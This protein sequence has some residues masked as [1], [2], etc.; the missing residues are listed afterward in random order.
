MEGEFEKPSSYMSIT[1]IDFKEN[2]DLEVSVSWMPEQL[3]DQ[4]RFSPDTFREGSRFALFLWRLACGYTSM[5]AQTTLLQTAHQNIVTIKTLRAIFPKVIAQQIE[6]FTLNPYISEKELNDY[7]LFLGL[8][9][10]YGRQKFWAKKSSE[11]KKYIFGDL[12]P[13]FKETWRSFR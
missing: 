9:Y 8:E 11:E 4:W 1:N 10:M 13:S 3:P 7:G 2:G 5:H 6:T 12:Y